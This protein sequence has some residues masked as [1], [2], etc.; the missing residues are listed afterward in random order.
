MSLFRKFATVGGATMV[1]RVLGFVREALIAA[2]LGAGPYADAFYQ[3]FGFPNL[4]RRILGEGAFNSAFIPLFA[5]ELEGGGANAARTFA[6]QVLAVLVT[7]L[8]DP[9]MPL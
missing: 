7:G 5:K 4:F 9:A 1:S 6:E 3:A 8:R 2:A